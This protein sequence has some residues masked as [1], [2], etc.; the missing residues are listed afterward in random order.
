MR[1][2]VF[3]A[4]AA[5]AFL[6]GCAARPTVQPTAPLPDLRAHKGV[7]VIVDAPAEIRAKT[8]YEQTAVALQEEFVTQLRQGG[9]F[10]SVGTESAPERTLLAR[11]TIEDLNYVHGA[12]RG[13]TGIFAGRAV[14][15]VRMTLTDRRS[16]R[17]LGSVSAADESSAWQG[18]FAPTTSRQ[19]SAIVQQL[20]DQL[21]R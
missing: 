7:Q 13:L 16:G 21:K 5:F 9:R 4:V 19:V 10:G 3:A 18:V 11:L 15:K 20:A 6:A 1:T 8:G 17:T 14:L 2:L 12:T